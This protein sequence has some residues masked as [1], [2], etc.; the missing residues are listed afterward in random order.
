MSDSIFNQ[1]K[2]LFA[3]F[4]SIEGDSIK[5][6]STIKDD[7]GV[8]S[9]DIVSIVTEIENAFDLKISDTDA[10]GLE[11]VGQVVELI[12]AAKA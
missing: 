7:L 5:V 6:E 1:V 8:D 9:V 11:T 2:E 4:L 10:A 12:S 3:D